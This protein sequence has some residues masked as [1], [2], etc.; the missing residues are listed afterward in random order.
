LE[1]EAFGPVKAQCAS[2]GEYQGGEVRVS[3]SVGE[4]PHRNMGRGDKK[5]FKVLNHQENANQNVYEVP[6]YTD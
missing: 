5:M 1:G 2:V 4:Y 6:S 3:G